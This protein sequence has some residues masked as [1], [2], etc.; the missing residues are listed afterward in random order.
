MLKTIIENKRE[1]KRRKMEMETIQAM[2]DTIVTVAAL[3]AITLMTKFS[4]DSVLR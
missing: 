1:E 3:A 2:S 4:L